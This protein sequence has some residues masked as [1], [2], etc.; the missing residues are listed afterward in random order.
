MA[1][2][3]ALLPPFKWRGVQYPV[4][5]RSVSFGHE[6][7]SS[8][9]QYRD[10][11]FIEQLGAHSLTF[12]YTV[13]MREDIAIKADVYSHL[14]TEGLPALFRDMRDRTRGI[15]ED[16]IY[17]SF[18][19]VPQR[20]DEEI[21]LQRRDG[22]DV[23]IEFTHSPDIAAD[24]AESP[25]PTIQGLATDAGALDAEIKKVDWQQEPSPEPSMDAINAITG[26]GG[27]LEANVGKFTSA[28]HD[29]AF[30]LEKI[31][32][33]AKRLENPDGFHIQQAARRNRAAVT[34]LG[35]RAKDPNKRIVSVSKAYQRTIS[36]VASE[37][38]MTVKELT[39]LNPSLVRLPYVPANQ[40]VL[41]FKLDG[42]K[43]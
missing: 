2:V 1:D 20:F 16:P 5:S 30:K 31:E 19:C 26:V 34:E 43:R 41:V 37:A 9:I 18:A 10:N 36:T 7:A 17:G 15:L 40:P 27:Q 23:Q 24:F 12:R 29:T 22:V 11:E 38:G 42:S 13:A 35:K 28:L 8:R 33:Q 14:F 25:N 4:T 39:D 21:D 32:T 6:G 3:V